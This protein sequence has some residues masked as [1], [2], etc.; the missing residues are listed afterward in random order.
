RDLLEMP[1]PGADSRLK[2]ILIAQAEE[3]L[4]MLAPPARP[5]S[6]VERVE[7][8]LADGLADGDPSLTRGADR[9]QLSMRTVPRRLRAAGGTH[10]GVV[11]QLRLDLA[12]RSL[13]GAK[14][15]QRQLA[16]A[17]GYSGAGAFH[18]AFK[19][20]SGLTPGQVREREGGAI[21]SAKKA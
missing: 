5:Q 7:Q 15:S 12:S 17:L 6:F 18:R 20:W 14:V 13:A 8:T 11:R 21:V 9:L 1:Q 2:N 16:R 10:R 4:A 19:R 3:L